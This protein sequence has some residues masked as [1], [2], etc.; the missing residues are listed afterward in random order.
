MLF[1]SHA[2]GH[3]PIFHTHITVIPMEKNLIF[4]IFV[5]HM[6]QVLVECTH[7]NRDF[8]L[9]LDRQ[10]DTSLAL[11]IILLTNSHQPQPYL[12]VLKI[13]MQ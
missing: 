4:F 5:A 2:L 3:K 13:S 1:L 7:A 8:W 12:N 11:V 10:V 9:R 6:S